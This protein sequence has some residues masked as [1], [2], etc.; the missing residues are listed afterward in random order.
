MYFDRSGRKRSVEEWRSGELNGLSETYYPNGK[1]AERTNWQDGTQIGEWK[2]FFEDGVLKAE[3]D[4]QN[5]EPEGSM[6]YYYPNGKLEISGKIRNSFRDGNWIY[7]NEDG[8]I[9]LQV[10]YQWGKVIQ[11]KKENGVFKEYYNE[12]IPKSEYTYAKGMRN[13]PFKEYYDQG[14]W[15]IEERPEGPKGEPAES[16]RVLKGVQIQRSGKYVN[17]LLKGEVRYFNEN[18]HPDKVEVYEEGVLQ[19]K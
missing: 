18:G 1:V 12:D 3:A 9:Q 13:G 16:V 17:D 8:S 2:Q 14:E 6:K 11:E 10:L 7:Y 15:V 19:K 4:Y 5:G